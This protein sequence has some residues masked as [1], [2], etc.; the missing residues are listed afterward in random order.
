MN[1][2]YYEKNL[3]K[4]IPCIVVENEIYST[5]SLNGKELY[6]RIKFDDTRYGDYN[7]N[8]NLLGSHL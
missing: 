4:L 5:K 2:L 7:T 8:Y 3:S 6:V 1:C